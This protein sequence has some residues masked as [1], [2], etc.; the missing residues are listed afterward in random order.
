MRLLASN[1]RSEDGAMCWDITS[2]DKDISFLP[3]TRLTE[4][5]NIEHVRV[6][7]YVDREANQIVVQSYNLFPSTDRR[8]T[9]K[10][11]ISQF[12]LNNDQIIYIGKNPKSQTEA[13]TVSD[14]FNNIQ[15]P[16]TNYIK[17]TH[18]KIEIRKG[19]VMIHDLSRGSMVVMEKQDASKLKGNPINIS[20][21]N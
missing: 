4:L 8:S 21:S 12:D 3:S 1:H 11:I 5:I 9:Y 16:S 19:R 14:G 10:S 15:I 17:D 2:S 18:C 6:R 13:N 7:I 20:T